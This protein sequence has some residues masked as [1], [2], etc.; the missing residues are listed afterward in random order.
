M[1]RPAVWC[2]VDSEAGSEEFPVR[3][4]IGDD[5]KI[6][7]FHALEHDDGI[8]AESLELEDGRGHVETVVDAVANAQQ[9][10]GI[11]RFDHF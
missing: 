1:S 9:L 11:V 7:P 5:G 3:R 10:V 4:Y 2:R 8:P 6:E